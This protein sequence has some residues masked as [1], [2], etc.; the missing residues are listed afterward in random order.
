MGYTV[1][2]CPNEPDVRIVMQRAAG[3]QPYRARGRGVPEGGDWRHYQW[4]TPMAVAPRFTAYYG[5]A[6][7]TRF[8]YVDIIRDEK[9]PHV[10]VLS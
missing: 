4:A 9:R 6:P 2:N 5:R 10:R 7:Y 8:E 1:T 3:D